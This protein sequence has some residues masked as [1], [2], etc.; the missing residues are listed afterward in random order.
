MMSKARSLIGELDAALSK[1]SDSQHLTILRRVT[2]LFLHGSEIFSDDYVAIFDDVI[3]RLIEKTEPRALVELSTR[4]AP[5]SKAPVNVMARLSRGDDI[6]VSGPVLERSNVLTEQTLTEIAGTKGQKHLAAIAGRAR[7][8]E[9]VT[10]ILVDRGN[11]EVAH[12]VTA[13]QGARFSELGFVK[14]IGRAKT[15]KSLSA[16]IAT[17]T[18]MPPELEPFLNLALAP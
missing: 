9:T 8:G 13:N 17:R 18:D 15:D 10:D 12:K 14:L 7:I 11:S 2:D 16:L 4:L 3:C 5:V 1:A 6:A